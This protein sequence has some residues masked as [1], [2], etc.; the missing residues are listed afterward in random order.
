MRVATRPEP[1]FDCRATLILGVGNPLCGDDGAGPKLIGLLSER[2]LPPAVYLQDAGLPG[3]EMPTWLEGW[4]S[5]FLVDAIEMGLNAGEWRSFHPEQVKYW[6][7]DD[8]LS[9]HQ[10]DLACG[11]A[12]AEALDRLPQRLVIY[13]IQPAQTEPGKPLS[14]QVNASL[15]ELADQIILDL[16]REKV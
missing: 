2:D 9:L 4:D 13:G 5:V 16:Q 1:A 11:L 10:P 7:E 14:R 15:N 12:L 6:L 3:W 8:T